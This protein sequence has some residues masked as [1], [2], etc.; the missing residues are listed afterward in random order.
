[1]I[2]TAWNNGRYHSSGVGYGFKVDSANRDRYFSK[3]WKRVFLELEGEVEAV[4]VNVDKLSFWGSTCRELI[5]KRI[6][7]WLIKNGKAPW[8]K[9]YPPK[10]KME[11]IE[12]N[13]FNVA[14]I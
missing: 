8:T 14:I 7:E 6:G 2:V 4:V 5:N 1:M 12:D 11:H 9:G 13:R 10:M 3:E